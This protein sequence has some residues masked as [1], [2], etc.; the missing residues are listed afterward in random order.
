MCGIYGLDNMQ[1]G[2]PVSRALIERMTALIDHRGSDD[3]GF[4]LDD[5]LAP[6]FARLSI[7]AL[8]GGHQPMCDET[9]DVRVVSNGEIWNYKALRQSL[10]EKGHILSEPAPQR[11]MMC[12]GVFNVP[13]GVRFPVFID[14][15]RLECPLISVGELLGDES[16]VAMR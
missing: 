16:V 9:G 10:L 1:S 12:F 6:G 7:I 13:D 11:W 8:A 15:P 2:A 5:N 4:H 3:S 14:N